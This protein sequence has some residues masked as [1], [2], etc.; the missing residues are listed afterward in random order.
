MH[1]SDE[2]IGKPYAQMNCAQLVA[3]RL[4]AVGIDGLASDI[5]GY[6]E[7]D[8]SLRAQAKALRGGV[9]IYGE[10]RKT[11]EDGLIAFFKEGLP[12]V[13]LVCEIMG[14]VYVL[15]A[16]KKA[17]QVVREPIDR[18]GPLAMYWVKE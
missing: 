11:P 3:D 18:V 8:Q 16:S 12:H 4:R 17:G 14:K 13:G 6:E 1:W 9:P 10:E 15:H 5:E 2:Y 7:H